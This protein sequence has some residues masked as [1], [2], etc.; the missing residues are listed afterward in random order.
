VNRTID[1]PP[2]PVDTG[3]LARM[4]TA[5]L[6]YAHRAPR[7]IR[8]GAVLAVDDDG[9][10]AAVSLRSASRP[11]PEDPLGGGDAGGPAPAAASG[12]PR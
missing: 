6:A 11:A 4:V 1:S 5:L 8:A 9:R 10:A 12:F 2:R 3:S 7:A